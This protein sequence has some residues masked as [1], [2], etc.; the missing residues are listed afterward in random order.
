MS[1]NAYPCLIP[2]AAT[3]ELQQRLQRL[4]VCTRELHFALHFVLTHEDF[5]QDHTDLRREREKEE[6]DEREEK[7]DGENEELKDVK[8]ERIERKGY[9]SVIQHKDSYPS[10]LIVSSILLLLLSSLPNND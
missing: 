7:R 2:C 9:T 10:F 6:D 4:L 3:H 8:R 1:D 5:L